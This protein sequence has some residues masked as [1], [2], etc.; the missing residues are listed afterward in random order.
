M[1]PSD[2]PAAIIARLTAGKP[3]RAHELDAMLSALPN[4]DRQLLAR[5]I[6]RYGSSTDLSAL[7][8]PSDDDFPMDIIPADKLLTSDWPEPVWAIP[9]LLP[10]GLTILAGAPKVGKSWLALQ[11]AQAVASGGMIFNL[12]VERGSVLYLALEDPPRRLKER[13]TQQ[14]WPVGLNADFLPV[15]TFMDQ[16]GDL[17]NGGSERLARQVDLHGYRMLA[18]D[19]LSRSI[20]GD[21]QDVREMTEWL[22]PLQEMAH[23][24]NSVI[25]LVDHHKKPTGFDQ[26]VIAD[27]LGSTAKGAMADTVM[28]LYRERGK[29]GARLSITGRE[30]EE[31]VL[32][33]YFDR[34]SGCWQ[35]EDPSPVMTPTQ[36]ELVDALKSLGLSTPTELA[37]AV[38]DHRG[39]VYRQL[40]DLEHKGYVRKLDERWDLELLR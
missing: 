23:E 5:T 12:R 26:D 6:A 24:K 2:L 14:G 22:T 7:C 38:G 28:G 10:V 27:I 35:Q 11:I 29:P 31:K 40:V 39:S 33:L 21:Q 25:I 20:Q 18:I 1:T 13:M 30:V 36:K 3:D 17:R 4:F 8:S 16:I 34:V 32:D 37:R 19:T 9:G 15:G